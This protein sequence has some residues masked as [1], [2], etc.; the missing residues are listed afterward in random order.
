MN[1]ACDELFACSRLACDQH[2]GVGRTDTI[3]P[4]QNLFKAWCMTHDAIR[5]LA[6]ARDPTHLRHGSNR[7]RNVSVVD[8]GLHDT[9]QPPGRYLIAR[10]SASTS[11]LSSNGFFRNAT[12]PA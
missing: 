1:C 3:D 2:R 5:H 4:L 6:S 9:L 12:A 8:R 10:C 7:L 11:V